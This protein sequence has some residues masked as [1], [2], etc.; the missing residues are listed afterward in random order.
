MT[1]KISKKKFV[2][3]LKGWSESHK[4]LVPSE[5]GRLRELDND[6]RIEWDAV[7]VWPGIKE[8]VFLPRNQVVGNE[9]YVPEKKILLGV[10]NCDLRALTG[11]MDELFLG[12]E[13]VDPVYKKWRES[14]VLV[15]VDCN[16]P[17]QTCFCESVGGHPFSDYGFDLNITVINDDLLLDENSRA[18]KD[19]I[20][21]LD[22]EQ[23]DEEDLKKREDL[24]DTASRKVKQN[25]E[26]NYK[27]D[28]FGKKVDKNRDEKY[29]MDKRETCMQCG[30]CNFCCPT[31]YCNVLNELSSSTK[32]R[33]VLQWDSCQFPGYARVAGGA[34][35][36]EELWERFRHR[37]YC[38]FKLMLGEFDM[39]GCTG[40]GRCIQVCPGEID[41]R[42]TV[43]GLYE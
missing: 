17:A 8:F 25:F 20:K 3:A 6:V 22:L 40:C 43:K 37:Y 33:K 5:Q 35:P 1:Y 31:C 29:W 21:E 32:M 24:R 19:L 30:G 11:V 14:V 7:P 36:R 26:L 13:P 39:P 28:E 16:L 10:R 42:E 15:S 9:D 27:E 34:N 41:I 2:E 12:E 38:K 23:A 4:V 18:G